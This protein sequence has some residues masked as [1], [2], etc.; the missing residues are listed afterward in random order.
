MTIS[1]RFDMPHHIRALLLAGAATAQG[2][3]L[4]I[5]VVVTVVVPRL[6]GNAVGPQ[7]ASNV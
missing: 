7:P 2:V 3:A 4:F 6:R 5:N 1:R